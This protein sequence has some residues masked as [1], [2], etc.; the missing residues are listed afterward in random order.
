MDLYFFSFFVINLVKSISTIVWTIKILFLY[1]NFW[2]NLRLIAA[3]PNNGDS[4][5][6]FQ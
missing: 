5:F 3:K 2:D 1:S 6:Q 4:D